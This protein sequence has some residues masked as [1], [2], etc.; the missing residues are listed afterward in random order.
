MDVLEAV[1]ARLA[2]VKA[3]EAEPERPVLARLQETRSVARVTPPGTGP[4]TVYF[5]REDVRRRFYAA[6][7]PL[8]EKGKGYE[9]PPCPGLEFDGAWFGW[10]H[11]I[12]TLAFLERKHPTE[13][14]HGAYLRGR[15]AH[16]AGRPLTSNPFHEREGYW[17]WI[18]FY[19]GWW[20]GWREA[21]PGKEPPDLE[22]QADAV[23]TPEPSAVAAGA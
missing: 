5:S 9:P 18:R 13:N 16:D 22:E 4:V 2:E 14:T 8:L 19:G 6:M 12:Y 20:W 3:Q 23:G 11:A 10:G 7:E 17:Q 1:R 15:F 21:N